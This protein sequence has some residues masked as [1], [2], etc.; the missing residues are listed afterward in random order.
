MKEKELEA[1]N[2][3]QL[4]SAKIAPENTVVFNNLFQDSSSLKAKPTSQKK[5]ATWKMSTKPD[6]REIVDQ[7]E[8]SGLAPKTPAMVYTT[9]NNPPVIIRK[10]GFRR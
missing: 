3:S 7:K 10:S 2:P 1:K 8:I 4:T 6:M 9:R 5:T